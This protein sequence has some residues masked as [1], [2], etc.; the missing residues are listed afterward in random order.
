V[1]KDAHDA[2]IY[3]GAESTYVHHHCHAMIGN[4]LESGFRVVFDATDLF[5]RQREVLHRPADR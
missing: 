4:L 2:P 1:R 3:T 5:R